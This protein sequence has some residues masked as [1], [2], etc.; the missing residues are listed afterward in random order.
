MVVCLK[1][2]SIFDLDLGPG[3]ELD[4]NLVLVFVWNFKSFKSFKSFFYLEW[5]E[6]EDCVGDHHGK[7]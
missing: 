7:R 3:P 6:E 2:N 1:F 4:V 5:V